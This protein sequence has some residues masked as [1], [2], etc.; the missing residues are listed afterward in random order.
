MLSMLPKTMRMHEYGLRWPSDIAAE[1]GMSQ[2][3][4]CRSK[5]VETNERDL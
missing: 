4:R 3:F 5:A 1:I 2:E